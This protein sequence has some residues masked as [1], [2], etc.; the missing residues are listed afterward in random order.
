MTRD[1]ERDPHLREALRHAPDAQLQ[2]PP[3]LSAFILQEARAKARDSQPAAPTSAAQ[4][5]TPGPLAA[6]WTWL[7]R[8]AVATGFAGVMAATLVGLMWWDRPMDEAMPRSPVP[9]TAPAAAQA[10]AE[11]PPASAPGLAAPIGDAARQAKELAPAGAAEPAAAKPARTAPLAKKSADAEEARQAERKRAGSDTSARLEPLAEGRTTAAR[12]VERRAEQQIERA[13]AMADHAAPADT[14]AAP[15]RESALPPPALAAAP[16]AP[17]RPA[18][19]PAPA[20]AGAGAAPAPATFGASAAAPQRLRAKAELNETRARLE[21][22]AFTGIASLRAEVATDPAQWQ[23]QRGNG[24]A[25][26]M[27]DAVY[28]WLARLDTA[29]ARRWEPAQ[30]GGTS[31]PPLTQALQL[32]RD[33]R[34]QH[35]VWLTE[36]EVLWQRG[37][38]SWR[39][40]LAPEP[41]AALRAAL[42]SAAP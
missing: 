41:L 4:L 16:A 6:L 42:D 32:W 24:A 37:Q 38:T 23:W 20:P 31:A 3:A 29:T 17:P 14:R 13:A 12:P 18:T 40:A 9:A 21:A 8:P 22:E 26:A 7:T 1:D 11:A 28:A 33:G 2:P 19:A 34:L 36:R 5:A 39:V 15:L 35:S 10:S 27:N 30:S 25:Q